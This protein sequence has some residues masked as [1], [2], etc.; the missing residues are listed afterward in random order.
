M[1][2]CL[3]RII[4]QERY[5]LLNHYCDH[6]LLVMRAVMASGFVNTEIDL[7]TIRAGHPC[8]D[9]REAAS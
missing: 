9:E 7:K 1:T 8:L 2:T 3:D 6:C 5:F 4:D